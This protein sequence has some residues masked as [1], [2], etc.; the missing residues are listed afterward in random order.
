MHL[1]TQTQIQEEPIVWHKH[2]ELLAS[3]KGR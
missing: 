2:E 1:D 3:Y